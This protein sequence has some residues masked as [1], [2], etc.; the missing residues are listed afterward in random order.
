MINYKFKFKLK[1]KIIYLFHETESLFVYMRWRGIE[2]IRRN[3]YSF[4]KYLNAL[5]FLNFLFNTPL[6]ELLF[7]FPQFIFL[8]FYSHGLKIGVFSQAEDS[9]PYNRRHR[10]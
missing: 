9:F 3:L 8:S 10:L 1:F 5:K 7:M 2:I 6:H 4:N